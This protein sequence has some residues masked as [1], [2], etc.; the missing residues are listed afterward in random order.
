MP[1]CAC[2]CEKLTKG[3]VYLP[4]HDA[5]LRK[6]IE[7]SVGG[8]QSLDRLVGAARRFAAGELSDDEYHRITREVVGGGT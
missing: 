2:G 8:L 3:G 7:K 4:G 6:A 5:K 1:L